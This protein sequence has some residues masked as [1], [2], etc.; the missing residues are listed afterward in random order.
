M[1]IIRILKTNI[2]SNKSEMRV[3]TPNNFDLLCLG[4]FFSRICSE[5]IRN[6]YKNDKTTNLFDLTM[7]LQRHEVRQT[8]LF[9]KNSNA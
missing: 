2:D 3:T 1:I 7:S 8:G 9:G 5:S 4:I 6:Y